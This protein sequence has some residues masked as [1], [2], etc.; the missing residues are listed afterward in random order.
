MTIEQMK[1]LEESKYNFYDI[2]KNNPSI[3]LNQDEFVK[4]SNRCT[5]YANLNSMIHRGLET[6]KSDRKKLYKR[7]QD[8]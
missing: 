8:K 4:K 6:S 1:E 3:Q 2:I 5:L 7:Y